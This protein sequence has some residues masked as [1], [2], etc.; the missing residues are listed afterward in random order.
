MIEPSWFG[1]MNS[2]VVYRESAAA[3]LGVDFDEAFAESNIAPGVVFLRLDSGR[4]NRIDS[5]Y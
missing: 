1:F 2:A 5:D 4:D 3:V